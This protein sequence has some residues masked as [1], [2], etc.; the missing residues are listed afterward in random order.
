[1]NGLEPELVE[2]P[3]A[4]AGALPDDVVGDGAGGVAGDGAGGVVPVVCARSLC[5]LNGLNTNAAAV[6]ANT[7]RRSIDTCPSSMTDIYDGDRSAS[8]CAPT[9]SAE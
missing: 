6:A 8:S 9:R 4:A 7:S 2:D 1:V 3:E 5:E